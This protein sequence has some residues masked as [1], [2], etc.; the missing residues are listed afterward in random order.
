M[1]FLHAT[2]SWITG[3]RWDFKLFLNRILFSL[4]PLVKILGDPVSPPWEAGLKFRPVGIISAAP[5]SLMIQPNY[6]VVR[7]IEQ[8][9]KIV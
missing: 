7:K 9:E 5:G 8:L 1:R 6:I 3:K 4:S 2:P